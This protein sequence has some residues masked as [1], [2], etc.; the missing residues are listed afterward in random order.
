MVR[1]PEATGTLGAA[2]VLAQG[3]KCPVARSGSG[4][5]SVEGEQETC[6]C[7]EAQ[8]QDEPVEYGDAEP[9]ALNLVVARHE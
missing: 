4:P 6:R 2:S 1:S 9:V 3:Q 8:A 5:Q 7:P